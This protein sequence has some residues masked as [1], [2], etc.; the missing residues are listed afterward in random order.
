M[1]SLMSRIIAFLFFVII[2]PR[3]VAQYTSSNIFAHNDYVR[4]KPFYTA[5]NLKVGYIE[6]DVFLQDGDLLVAH[7]RNEIVAGNNLDALYLKPLSEEIKK[8]RGWAYSDPDCELT[9]MIDLKTAGVP[10]LNAIIDRLKKYPELISARKLTVM[11]SGNVPDPDKW[12]EYPDYI[13]FDGR[14]E[15]EYTPE[16]FRRISMIS[17]SFR[18]HIKWDGHRPLTEEERGKITSLMS[19]ASSHGKKFRFWGTPDF[20]QAWKTFMDLKMD[21]IVTDDVEALAAFLARQK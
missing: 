17:T 5:Y 14:P 18:S 20:E 9:L 13:C 21:V 10:T 7:H 8:N 11:I 6:A 12:S 4:V 2:C 19:K 16:Q 15:I 1:P 3:A